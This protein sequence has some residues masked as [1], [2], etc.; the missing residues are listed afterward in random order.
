MSDI[1][2]GY[3]V[4]CSNL[5][6]M[7]LQIICFRGMYR[8]CVG[9]WHWDCISLSPSWRELW[10]AA[11]LAVVGMLVIHL[12]CQIPCQKLQRQRWNIR[13]IL[14]SHWPISW[15]V[16]TYDWWGQ[17]MFGAYVRP[18]NCCPGGKKQNIKVL[19]ARVE[20]K[21]HWS[22]TKKS[23]GGPRESLKP[24]CVRFPIAGKHASIRIPA[25]INWTW[26]HV[27]LGGMH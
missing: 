18:G 4:L 3:P 20:G 13:Q 10:V 22:R 19:R 23:G 27:R 21:H 11:L 6:Q 15:S 16:P 25:D 1:D 12:L 2:A 26:L 9:R 8:I 14:Q 24:S 17:N 7:V 5:M